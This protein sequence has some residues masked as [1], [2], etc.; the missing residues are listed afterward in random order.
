MRPRL[1]LVFLPTLYSSVSVADEASWN[2]QQSNDSKEWVCIGDSKAEAKTAQPPQAA[3]KS[4]PAKKAEPAITEVVPVAEPVPVDVDKDTVPATAEPVQAAEPV[5][6]PQVVE[7]SP[8]EQPKPVKAV[9]NRPIYE[10]QPVLHEAGEPVPV[11]MKPSK[12]EVVADNQQ[13]PGWNCDAGGEGQSWD[14][15]LKGPD[16]KGEAQIVASDEFKPGFLLDPAFDLAQE[17]TFNTLKSQLPYDPWQ[18]CTIHMGAPEGFVSRKDLRVSAPLDI[19]SNYSELYD[20]EISSYFGNVEMSRADQHVQSDKANYDTVSETLDLQGNVYYSEDELALYSNTATLK[21]QSDQARLRDAL[22]IAPSTPIRGRAQVVYRD[23]KDLSRYKDVAYTSCRPGNQD[24]VVHASELKLNKDS[25]KGSAKN[26]WLE[27]KG[28]PVFYSPYLSFPMD[29]RR[30]SGFLAPSFGSTQ[31]SGFDLSVPY[32]WNIAPNYDA[33]FKPRYMTKRGILLGGNFRYLTESSTGQLSGEYLPNDNLLNKMR[34]QVGLKNTTVFMPNL[35]S[36]LDFNYLSDKD[37]FRDLGNALNLNRSSYLRS[38]ADVKY[39]NDS[40]SFVTRVENY[41]V[42]DKAILP[43]NS[44]Y[45]RLPQVRLD[46]NRSFDVMPMPL[47]TAMENEYVYFQHDNLVNG[48]RFNIKPSLTVP[49]ET[50]GAFIKPKISLQQTNY[51]LSQQN[52]TAEVAYALSQG[53]ADNAGLPTSISRTLPIASID[54]GLYFEKELDLAGNAFTHTIEPRLFYLYIPKTNQNDIPLFDT[55]LF[56]FN[57]SSLFRE[58]RFSGADRIQDANQITTAVTT[59]L[60]DPKTGRDRLKLDIG[61]IFYFKDRE[62]TLC[63]DYYSPLCTTGL[64]SQRETNS[65]SNLV[66]ELNAE[67]TEHISLDTGM[68][69]DYEISDVVRNNLAIHYHNEGNEL[70]NIGYRYRK[71]PLY[72]ARNRD[73][74]MSDISFHWPVYDNWYAVGRWQY[75][76][77]DNST[78]ESFFGL[79]KESC[80]WRFRVIG[81]R[82][83]NTVNR[84]TINDQT[85]Q[86]DS[87]TG[88]F[89]Q[90]ELKGLTGIGQK[91]DEFFEQNIYGYRKPKD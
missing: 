59:R 79:E 5:V 29:N 56:D 45:R 69:W 63:G 21:L 74:I 30:L 25:G 32:Y 17:Q 38:Q 53:R 7:S 19:H 18:N 23:S 58:N 55:S 52:T 20:A 47:N 16:P 48:Q 44:P 87:Q 15:T 54:S 13:R 62:V 70:V 71:N 2:C 68:Q 40:V 10:A 37:Y 83:V 50:A 28:V 86:G 39:L 22:F 4:E 67:V 90:V 11:E 65:L 85:P 77:L 76:L 12:P 81:R 26:T 64:F 24:W 27:F 42:I 91:L 66:T 78:K 34:Y 46:L 43:Q 89:V 60:V 41:Q 75:S 33:T 1:F 84:N 35:S 9:K 6:T 36:N 57:Y 3:D 80:C 73:I 72:P 51:L 88:L 61:Q 49:F 14:C 8:E 82:W 31:R